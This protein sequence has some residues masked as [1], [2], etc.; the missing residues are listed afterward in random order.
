MELCVEKGKVLFVNLPKEIDHHKVSKLA[1]EI[2]ETIMMKEADTVVFDFGKVEFMDSSGIGL[3][4]GRYRNMKCLGGNVYTY[5]A[6]EYIAK[7]IALS[8]I[9]K[10]IRKYEGTK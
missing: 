8:G 7:I 4:I 9:E 6:N 5:G 2:D 3:M 10:Y 1:V